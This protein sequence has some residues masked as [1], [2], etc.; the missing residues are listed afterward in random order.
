MFS[1]RFNVLI[2]KII[3]SKKNHFNAFLSEKHFEPQLLSKNG[4]HQEMVVTSFPC[5]LQPK[6]FL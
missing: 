3:F 6:T 4:C 2:S 5:V 1:D